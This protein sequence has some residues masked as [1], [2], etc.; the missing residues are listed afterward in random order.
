M[1]MLGN[2]GIVMRIDI[3]IDLL[4][5]DKVKPNDVVLVSVLLACTCLGALD[6]GRWIHVY[7]DKSG[8]LNSSNISTALGNI[9]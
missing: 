7:V 6:Q 3:F 8:V 4:C 1:V 5:N 9:H 2:E